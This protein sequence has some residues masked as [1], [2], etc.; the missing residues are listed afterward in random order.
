MKIIVCSD[1]HVDAVTNGVPRHDDVLR[2]V[3]ASV[4]AAIDE[5]A[6]LWLFAGDWADPDNARSF[7]SAAAA[8]EVALR[9]KKHNVDQAWVVGN[10][11]VIEDGHGTHVLSPLKAAGFRVW[12]R[13]GAMMLG[14]NKFSD[15]NR[16]D[17]VGLPYSSRATSYDPDAAFRE[18]ARD[19]VSTR[20]LVVGHLM[21]EGISPGSE[22]LDMPRGRDVFWPM[23]AIAERAPEAIVVAG[24]YHKRQVYERYGV[25]VQVVGSLERLTHGEESN[26][27]G[28]L[29]L[30]L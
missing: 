26:S 12:D 17:V 16:L 18:L 22:T 29:V 30:D 1:A 2:A 25:Q 14:A 20:L 28:F 24:H 23:R 7:R 27:P 15:K 21:L 6:A 4:D 5:K 9:L 8:I 3:D 19:R 13:P 11:D 10:H